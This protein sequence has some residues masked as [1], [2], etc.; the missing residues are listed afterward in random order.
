LIGPPVNAIATVPGPSG[1]FVAFAAETVLA[2]ELMTVVLTVSNARP[3]Y[4]QFTG[5]AA[6]PACVPGKRGSTGL[7]ATIVTRAR[8]PNSPRRDRLL[9]PFAAVFGHDSII[10]R[11]YR[12][13]APDNS[14]LFSFARMLLPA[15]VDLA[16]FCV[17]TTRYNGSLDFASVLT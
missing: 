6:A 1:P 13:A 16:N 15:D 2:F 7:P 9:D 12:V 4:P 3:P 11:R 17:P 10:A 14:L 8:R 5:V